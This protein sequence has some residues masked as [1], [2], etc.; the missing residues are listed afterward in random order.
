MLGVVSLFGDIT[1]EGARSITGPFLYTLGASDAMVG[2]IS[3]LG[4]F[5]SYALRLLSGPWADRT[6]RYWVFVFIGYGLILAI[7]MLALA[8]V[9]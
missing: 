6:G 7:P 8:G 3:G 5:L 2:L 4:D 9:W 1:Y